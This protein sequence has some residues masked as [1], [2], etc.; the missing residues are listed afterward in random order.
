VLS[1]AE[2]LRF[3]FRNQG[4]GAQVFAE[5]PVAESVFDRVGVIVSVGGDGTL[6]GVA[7]TA[8]RL[9]IPVFAINHGEVGFLSAVDREHALRRVENLKTGKFKLSERLMLSVSFGGAQHLALNDAVIRGK[10]C[11]R[12]VKLAAIFSGDLVAEYRADGIIVASPTGSTAYNFSAGGPIIHPNLDCMVL[13]PVCQHGSYPHSLVLANSGPLVVRGKEGEFSAYCDGN[14]IGH[15]SEASISI[16]E[17]KL[18]LIEME[19]LSFF[20]ILRKKL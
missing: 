4:V 12:L 19:N 10:N 20:D 15:G 7:A 8:A 6:L 9:E 1:F 16:F 13:T 3:E 11:A 18:K 5:Y 2:Q 17:K 14:P